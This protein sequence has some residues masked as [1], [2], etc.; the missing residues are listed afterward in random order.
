MNYAAVVEGARARSSSCWATTAP[1]SASRSSTPAS[2]AGTTTSPTRAS[3]PKVKVVNGQRVVK[4][5]DFVNG[6]TTQVR[7]QRPR[8]ARRRHH[9]GQRLR[10]ARARAPASP[11]RP[12]SSASRSSTTNGGGYISN[13]IAALD[14]VVA[15]RT[16]YNIRVVNLSVGAAVTESYLTDPLT[17]AAKRVVDA[18]RRRRHGGR[19]PRQERDDGQ[20]AVRRHHRAGQRALG[21]DGRRLQPRGHAHPHRRQD[22]RRSARAVRRRRDFN[23]KP[24][25]VATGVGIASLSVPGS[26]LLSDR[27]RRTCSTARSARLNKPY[28]SLTGTSMAAPIVTGTRRADAAGQPEAD[29]EPGQGDHRVHRAGHATTT[30]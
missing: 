18:G 30:R 13:V 25:V 4:F 19:Q 24:D 21:A 8:H 22:G 1:A 14:W 28:L 12:T 9:R 29:A 6:R 17:L 16:T 11:R 10:H 7:R 23:A 3:N 20:A 15:N 5:V 2:P 27:R 26:T